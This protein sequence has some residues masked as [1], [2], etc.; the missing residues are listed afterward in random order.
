MTT[1]YS[2]HSATKHHSVKELHHRLSKKLLRKLLGNET[3]AIMK[4]IN[5][6]RSDDQSSNFDGVK[7]A[8]NQLVGDSNTDLVDV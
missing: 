4:P 6:F 5:R 1:P 3:S 8:D 7:P 2:S